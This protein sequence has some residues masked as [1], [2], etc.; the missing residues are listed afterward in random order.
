MGL[1]AGTARCYVVFLFLISPLKLVGLGL[2]L[3]FLMCF[4]SVLLMAVFGWCG[5]MG[6]H[7]WIADFGLGAWAARGYVFFFIFISPLKLVGLG[8]GL[9]FLMCL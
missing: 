4:L 3:L 5:I 2:G 8:L 6:S 7:G 1:L 9:C